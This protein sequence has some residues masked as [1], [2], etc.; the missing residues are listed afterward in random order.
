MTA[1]CGLCQLEPDADPFLKATYF[2]SDPTGPSTLFLLKNN[3]PTCD[4][5]MP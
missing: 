5:D 1:I 2:L 3:Q 4:S